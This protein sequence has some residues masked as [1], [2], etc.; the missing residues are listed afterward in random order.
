MATW[1]AKAASREARVGATT[2]CGVTPKLNAT[3]LAASCAHARSRLVRLNGS[4][5]LLSLAAAKRVLRLTMLGGYALV[6]I[7][8]LLSS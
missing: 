3:A 1:R 8:F 6:G 7:I 2:S 5:I 4:I